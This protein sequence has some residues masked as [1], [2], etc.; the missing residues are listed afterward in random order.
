MF[1]DLN[2]AEKRALREAAQLA[3][4]RDVSMPSEDRDVHYLQARNPD[5]PF[6]VAGA[7]VHEIISI[8][9]VGAVIRELIEDVSARLS[10][11]IE[12]LGNRDRAPVEE[13]DPYDPNAVV[14]VAAILGEIDFLASSGEASLFVNTRTGEV[15]VSL[16]EGLDEFDDDVDFRKD[17]EW[18]YLLSR[19]DLDELGAMKKFAR[20][21][22]PAAGRDLYEALSG[23]G[24]FRRFRDVIHRR[25]LQQDWDQYRERCFADQICFE[26]EE[27]KIPFRK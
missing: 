27:R 2:K 21:A 25:G 23:G 15:R 19:Y 5:L 22:S 1:H 16:G 13:P 9:E 24:A 12:S 17:E 26:L 8:D 7:V 10:A 20:D 14:S 3:Y 4:D 18:L 11:S 6:V